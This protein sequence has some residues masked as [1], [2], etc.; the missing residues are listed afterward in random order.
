MIHVVIQGAKGSSGAGTHR[1]G[2]FWGSWGLVG[3]A[4]PVRKIEGNLDPT[5]YSNSSEGAAIT[6][7]FVLVMYVRIQ[8]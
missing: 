1:R 6:T 2:D 3:N 8:T 5:P 4:T 7:N